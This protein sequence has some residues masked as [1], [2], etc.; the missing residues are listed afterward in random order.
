MS[1][2]VPIDLGTVGY[3]GH[4]GVCEYCR[5]WPETPWIVAQADAALARLESEGQAAARAIVRSQS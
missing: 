2:P 3:L 5:R 1:L 4:L